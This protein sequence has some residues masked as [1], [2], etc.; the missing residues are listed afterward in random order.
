MLFAGVCER[1][2]SRPEILQAG[3]VKGLM[4]SLGGS[5]LVSRRASARFRFGSPF[6]K[7]CGLWR[8]SCDFVPHI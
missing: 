1:S 3:A 7:G 4:R 8:L 2:F 6:R 5:G